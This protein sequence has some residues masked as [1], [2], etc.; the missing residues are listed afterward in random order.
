M[1]RVKNPRWER[2]KPFFS[3]FAN[4]PAM[5]KKDPFRSNLTNFV[6]RPEL[7]EPSPGEEEQ[8]PTEVTDV[9]ASPLQRYAVDEYKLVLIMSGT[10]MPKAVIEDPIGNTWVVT[11][12]TPLGNRGGVIQNITQY[13]IVVREPDADKPIIKSLMPGIFEAAEELIVSH[14]ATGVGAELLTGVER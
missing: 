9:V 11:K 12:D 1:E 8:P 7:P 3:K 13:S 14:Q 6:A 10:V 2:I 5:A 4:E